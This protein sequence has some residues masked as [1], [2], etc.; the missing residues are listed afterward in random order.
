LNAFITSETG[1]HTRSEG[2][3]EALLKTIQRVNKAPMSQ[4]CIWVSGIG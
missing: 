2:R 4:S 3:G 1:K